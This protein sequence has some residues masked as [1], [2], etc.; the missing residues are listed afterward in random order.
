MAEISVEIGGGNEHV[1]T[2]TKESAVRLGLKAGDQVTV[3]I[4]AS[5]VVIAK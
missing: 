3:V 4:K 1:S 5:E 2:I